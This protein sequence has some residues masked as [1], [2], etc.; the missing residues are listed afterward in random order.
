MKLY[1]LF[2]LALTLSLQAKTS[3]TGNYGGYRAICQKAAEDTYY[4]ENFRALGEYRC[5]LEIEDGATFAQYIQNRGGLLLEKL[6]AFRKLDSLGSPLL[7]S[8]ESLGL[9]SATTLRYIFH[10]D[11]IRKY[12]SLPAQAKV[13]EIGAGFGGQC[14]IL[15]QLQSC[16]DYYI[17]D[18][19]E[20]EALIG[21]MVTT[22][23]LSNVHCM[24]IDALLPEEKIDL[25]ISNYAYSECDR[26]M[27]LEYFER[28]I[29]KAERGYLIYNQISRTDYGLDSLTPAEFVDLLKKSGATPRMRSELFAGAGNLLITW[30]KTAKGKRA[31]GE[32]TP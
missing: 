23:G 4:F 32:T 22:L 17:Y 29:K 12:F 18:L 15:Q 13:A 19:P 31:P 10:A 2:F 11:Q 3:I 6:E 5:A 25:V 9:F 30:D 1:S 24:P 27:Q 16:S 26:E 28:I 21:R 20:V 7:T 8:Y 14:Y